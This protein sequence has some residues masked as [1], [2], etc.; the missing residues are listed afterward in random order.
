MVHCVCMVSDFFYPNSGG[1][2]SHIFQLSQC[3]LERGHRVIVIT[4]FYNDRIGVKY[5]TNYLKVYYLP[6]VPFYN[7][8]ILP[9][10]VGS[11][12]YLRHIFLT[13]KV[14]IVH[15]HS[16]FSALAH[17]ALF[18]ASLLDIPSVFTDHSLFGF[19]DASA[20][21]TNSFLKYSL[22]NTS[23]TICVSHTGKEN[24]VLRSDVAA[25]NVFVIPN[26]VD[27]AKFRPKPQQ[28]R[29]KPKN[30][31]NV[32]TSG[33]YHVNGV[34]EKLASDATLAPS[35]GCPKVNYGRPV[36]IVL[37]SRLVYRKG[38]DFVAELIP[39]VSRFRFRQ[40]DSVSR[41]NFLIAGDGPKRILIEEVIEKHKLQKRVKML[42]DLK[43][44]DMRDKLLVKGDIFL[45]T[46]LTEAFC[47]AIVEALACG[48]TVVSTNVGGIPEVLPPRYI[49]LV[50]PNLAAIVAGI[51][52]AIQDLLD[53]RRPSADECN[54]FVRE[55]YCWRNVAERTEVVYKTVTDTTTPS[56]A[57]KVRNLWDCGP[58]AGPL[59]A[60]VY[61]ALHYLV[62]VLNCISPVHSS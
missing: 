47:M 54:Q 17:E 5:M 31:V 33:Y 21:V 38:I 53:G 22:A 42:G 39:I 34:G 26:A 16:A 62:L 51:K 12:P 35:K 20:I 19:S 29:T 8:S 7:K 40:G 15:G 13:E 43:H 10:I 3:L 18:V 9:T 58:M 28:Q 56:L 24:T 46:S 11:L 36:T 25:E 49:Y 60:M 27:S 37:G 50:E 14:D 1:V 44:S 41:V 55:S 59:M 52:Q 57:R 61:L 48:L 6:L 2:E 45:N 30:G 4:H 32:R 23:R